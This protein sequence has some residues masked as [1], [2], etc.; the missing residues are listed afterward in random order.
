MEESPFDA[1]RTR[2]PYLK[3]LISICRGLNQA[4]ARYVVM[5][6]MAVN[7]HGYIRATEDIDC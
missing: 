6:G 3:D 7:A 5:G 4:G 1:E 2:A